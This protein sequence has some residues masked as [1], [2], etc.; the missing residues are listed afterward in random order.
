MKYFYKHRIPSHVL[1][2]I[3]T[4]YMQFSLNT[5][6]LFANIAM[7]QFPG[8]RFYHVIDYYSTRDFKPHRSS[9]INDVQIFIGNTDIND[10][11]HA[12]CV[13][14][15]ASSKNVLIYDSSMWKRLDSKQLE[16]IDTLY[17]F[18]NDIVFMEPKS[19]QFDAPTCAV[20]ST[21]YANM[22]LLGS[23]PS[24][25]GFKLNEVYGDST[26]YMRFHILKILSNRKLTLMEN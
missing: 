7:E 12:I 24:K 19:L 21:I 16:I 4:E 15:E 22:L 10:G 5:I 18:K 13:Y 23:D 17:P 1:E 2:E 11:A 9:K 3:T 6:D 20:F 26:L 25:V 14:Y 8:I